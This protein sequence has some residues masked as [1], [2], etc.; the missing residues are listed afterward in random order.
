MIERGFS[1]PGK[2]NAD[3]KYILGTTFLRHA[4]VTY[5]LITHRVWLAAIDPV[6]A[7]S[8]PKLVAWDEKQTEWPTPSSTGIV[9]RES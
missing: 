9:G 1:G 6:K 7:K 5:D 8:R 3:L 4:Y 2:P